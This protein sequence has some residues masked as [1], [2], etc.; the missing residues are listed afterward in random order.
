MLEWGEEEAQVFGPSSLTFHVRPLEGLGFSAAIALL[1]LGTREPQGIPRERVFFPRRGKRAKH[2][3]RGVC[4]AAAEGT[5]LQVL[6]MRGRQTPP[7]WAKMVLEQL[8][9]FH[10]GITQ[11][12]PGAGLG[13]CSE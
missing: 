7:L 4:R 5:Y 1:R 9:S 3:M 10:E 8:I 12:Y 2:S 11:G 6:Q 13:P